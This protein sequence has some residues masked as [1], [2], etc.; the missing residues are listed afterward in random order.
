[1]ENKAFFRE[2]GE[3]HFVEV[4][5]ER[6]RVPMMKCPTC[7]NALPSNKAKLMYIHKSASRRGVFIQ[8]VIFHS[9][10]Q[11]MWWKFS[12]KSLAKRQK[13]VTFYCCASFE[14][15]STHFSQCKTFLFIIQIMIHVLFCQ[16]L[17][18][19]LL[20]I[21]NIVVAAF[22]CSLLTNLFILFYST[23]CLTSVAGWCTKY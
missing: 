12:R 8:P 7:L 9:W 6:T 20:D 1:M 11:W 21:N 5:T 17:S 2:G 23:I 10:K 3:L 13:M 4:N 16:M 22:C 19:R 14:L 18:E 15:L